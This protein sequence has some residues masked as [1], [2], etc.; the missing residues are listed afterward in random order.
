MFDELASRAAAIPRLRINHNFHSS[1]EDN[2]HRFLNV[3]LHGTYL[4]PHRHLAP[5]KTESFVCLEGKLAFFIY[6]GSGKIQEIHELNANGPV[7]GIDIAPGIWHTIL[8]LSSRAV[9]F[10]VKPGPYQVSTDKEFVDWAPEEGA[11]GV[12][13]FLATLEEAYR[14]H[15]LKPNGS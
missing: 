11:P 6:E 4:R 3:M 1:M 14:L 2:P 15:A 13:E 5:P 9:F 8:V 7:I 12:P 10:E